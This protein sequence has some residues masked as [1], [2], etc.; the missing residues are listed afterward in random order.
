MTDLPIVRLTVLAPML[1]RKCGPGLSGV[2]L[3]HPGTSGSTHAPS[4]PRTPV[5]RRPG[6]PGRVRTSHFRCHRIDRR[7]FRPTG[8]QDPLPDLP[9]VHDDGVPDL[10]TQP[11]LS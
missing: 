7:D 11:H 3:T 8:G 9:S 1:V 4:G 5:P 6:L 10:E 2:S